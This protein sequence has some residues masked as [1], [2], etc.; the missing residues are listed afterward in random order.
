MSGMRLPELLRVTESDSDVRIADSTGSVVALIT[1]GAHP[2]TTLPAGAER[3]VGQWKGDRLE[4]SHRTER[5]ANITRTFRL[6]ENGQLLE[7]RTKIEP[8]DGSMRT[9]DFKRVYRKVGSR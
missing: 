3:F 1:T 2:D 6:Q 5:G 7:I 8:E 4:E 9:M